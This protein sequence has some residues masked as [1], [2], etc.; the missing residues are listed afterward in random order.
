MGSNIT[1]AVECA[2][3]KE[4]KPFIDSMDNV[5]HER[6]S[7]VEIAVGDYQGVRLA[8]GEGGMGTVSAGAA[9]QLLIDRYE[10]DY[11][12]FSGIAG[13]LNPGLRVGD[14][15]LGDQLHYLETNTPIIA[16][17]APWL[18]HFTSDSELLDIALAVMEERGWRRIPSLREKAA[19]S[20]TAR[21]GEN[22]SENDGTTDITA[23][24]RRFVYGTIATS[25]QFNTDPEILETIRTTVYGDC[26]EME[27]AA[28]A[29]ICAKSEVPFLGI[30]ALSNQC[31]ESYESL[32]DH[33]NDLYDAANAAA[34]IAMG[35][36]DVIAQRQR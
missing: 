24:E 21:S 15:V 5:E 19:R 18:E 26:E 6:R 35:V 17:C 12:I 3:A 20:E 8:V 13:G 22:G 4:T 25:D 16:E 27:G 29:H 2:L 34:A 1:V 32:D 10:P 7:G 28:A 23:N 11:L 36:I 9:A 14:I 31:G 33:E 30:R